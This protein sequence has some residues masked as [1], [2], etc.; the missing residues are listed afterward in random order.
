MEGESSCSIT[1]V[2]CKFLSFFYWT[3][4]FITM[5]YTVILLF[6]LL[7]VAFGGSSTTGIVADTGRIGG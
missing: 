7:A 6:A 1:I 2:F 3:N 5:K 4:N